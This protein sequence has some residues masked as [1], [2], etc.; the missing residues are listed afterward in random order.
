MNDRSFQK[1]EIWEEEQFAIDASQDTIS[2][3]QALSSTLADIE[4]A[5]DEIKEEIKAQEPTNIFTHGSEDGDPEIIKDSITMSELDEI[6][7][8]DT[9][10][11]NPKFFEAAHEFM[12][13]VIN[14][15]SVP[16]KGKA[17]TE[18]LKTCFNNV[19]NAAQPEFEQI[20]R[21]TE[22]LNR[23]SANETEV[24]RSSKFCLFADE[25]IKRCTDEETLNQLLSQGKTTAIYL[26]LFKKFL[27]KTYA[28]ASY[29]LNQMS[30]M[31]E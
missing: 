30:K 17:F 19:K 10:S 31:C 4:P 14:Q 13:V 24:P 26:N 15:N 21:T 6:N 12:E 29:L 3:S 5:T 23:T 2:P 11:Y 28:E 9:I 22:Q 18:Y 20:N 25:L 7:P 16:K 8:P 27:V 1:R